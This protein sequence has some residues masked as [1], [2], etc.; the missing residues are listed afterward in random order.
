MKEA[1]AGEALLTRN[2][3]NPIAQKYYQQYLADTTNTT[4]LTPSENGELLSIVDTLLYGMG[5]ISVDDLTNQMKIEELDIAVLYKG[6]E[7]AIN[8]NT[9]FSV[10]EINQ[11]AQTYFGRKAAE[12]SEENKAT[13]EKFLEENSFKQGVLTTE[14][15][16]QY[17]ILTEGSGA[18]PKPTDR[19]KVHYEG[20]L[21]NGEVFDSSIARGEPAEFGV[22]QVIRGWVEALQM[23][24][25]GSKWE[26]YIPSDLAYGERGGPGGGIGPNETLIFQ[27]ELIEILDAPV[28]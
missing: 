7:D 23:M 14:S 18:S 8:G 1:E 19:V 9:S 6:M 15:G 20:K 24:K 10:E 22:T 12:I 25:P 11:I 28:E 21:I 3:F 5:A 26:L 27:V 4:V 2:D 16:L 13:G 17:K